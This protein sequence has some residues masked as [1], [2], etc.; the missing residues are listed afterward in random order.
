MTFRKITFTFI[1]LLLSML[2]V[3]QLLLIQNLTKDVR[4]KIAE[5]AFLV[6]RST[7]ETLLFRPQ[8]NYKRIAISKSLSATENIELVSSINLMSKEVNIS[9]KD[10]Q[11]DKFLTIESS[12]SNYKIPIPRTPIEKSLENLSNKTLVIGL[13]FLALGLAA[14]GSFARRLSKPLKDL[15]L[16]SLKV[17]QGQFGFQVI[18]QQGLKSTELNNTIEAFNQMSLKIEQLQQEN[19]RLQQQTQLNELTEIT[20]GLAHT[21]R[22]PLNTLNLAIDQLSN[23]NPSDT[24]NE[25]SKISKFQVQ[26]IDR[27]V[28]SLMDLLGNDTNLFENINLI[29]LIKYCKEELTNNSQ[30]E[31]PM[32]LEVDKHQAKEFKINAIRA[33]L[34]GVILGLLSNAVEST[35]AYLK[36]NSNTCYKVVIHL[37]KKNGYFAIEIKD[38][39][40]GFC[41]EVEG[42]LFNPHNT[43]KTYGAGMGLYLA[44]RIITIKYAG[45]LRLVSNSTDKIDHGAVILLTL[46]DRVAQNV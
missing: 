41:S 19:Q 29:E 26:R 14:S 20:R 4:S 2:F 44:H 3:L 45:D 22:N 10:G 23:D 27:W 32:I 25:L 6:S 17:G 1:A 8:K 42:K 16:A 12:G 11:L 30:R 39:G 15:Q 46:K 37:S 36:E 33:E 34:K 9:L 24:R 13:I 5:A 35:Q 21:I 7:V 18:Q 31:I 38:Q 28:K 43:N 40:K